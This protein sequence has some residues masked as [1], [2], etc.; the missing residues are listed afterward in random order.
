VSGEKLKA[1]DASNAVTVF[2]ASNDAQVKYSELHRQ[3]EAFMRQVDDGKKHPDSKYDALIYKQ[4]CVNDTVAT[5]VTS[6]AS[7]N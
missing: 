2:I 4:N 5:Q 1:V 6:L 3:M 7:I